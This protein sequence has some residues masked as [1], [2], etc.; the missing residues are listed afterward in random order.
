MY[1]HHNYQL[2]ESTFIFGGVKSDF[3]VLSHFS[4]KFLCAN[5][6]APDG[7]PRSAGSHLGLLGFA[8]CLCP[9]K[10]D[11]RLKFVK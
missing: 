7:T 8:V 5:R 10:K 6:L 3:Y 1:F 11:T 4:M 9:T 2:G